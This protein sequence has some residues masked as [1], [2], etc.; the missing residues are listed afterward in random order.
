VSS[1]PVVVVGAGWSGA[2]VAHALS[3][4][5]LRVEV[6]ES[7]P[8]VGG[9]SRVETINGVVYEPHGPHIFHTSNAHVAAFIDRL[10]LCRRPF[11]FRP[12]TEIDLGDGDRRLLSWPIQ[13]DEIRELPDWRRIETELDALPPEPQGDDLESYVVSMMG[14]RLYELFIEGYTRKQWGREPSTLSSSFAPKRIELRRDGYTRLFR[15]QFECFPPNGPNRAIESLLSRSA[16]TCGAEVTVD[17][18]IGVDAAAI[19][20]TAACDDFIG[21]PGA[22]EW[23]GV[24][25]RSR[26]V[27]VGDDQTLTESYVINRPSMSVPYTRTVETKHA[28]GQRI[29]GTVV[30][31]EYP[32]ADAR[33]YPVDTV[34]HHDARMNARLQEEISLALAPVPT[35]YCGRL[36]T[37]AYINQDEAIARAFDCAKE[38]LAVLSG[39]AA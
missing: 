21:A 24:Q 26:Y 39:V 3:E 20:V 36:A 17:K 15:D 14:R 28:T 6:L 38:V 8:F 19:V 32:G 23:R 9:H 25:L 12:L 29:G 30:S 2:V 22:L 18:L 33:H 4:A 27:P 5:G 10:G 11:A 35:F 34:D 31:E 37:Y 16:V 1:S 7:E 13:L